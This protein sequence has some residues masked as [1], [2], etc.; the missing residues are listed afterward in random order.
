M[1]SF[2]GI[3]ALALVCLLVILSAVEGK[4][5]RSFEGYI[6]EK[7]VQTRDG[8]IEVS[9]EEYVT[10]KANNTKRKIM[11]GTKIPY[12][13]PPLAQLRFQAPANVT[14]WTDP[15]NCNRG[16][17]DSIPACHQSKKM[18]SMEDQPPEVQ[19]FWNEYSGGE[20]TKDSITATEYSEDCLYLNVWA[21][22]SKNGSV[23]P[24]GSMGVG[25]FVHG[26]EFQYD[27]AFNNLYEGTSVAFGMN[28]VVVTF[29]YRLG[30]FGFLHAP[31]EKT[32]ANQAR[33]NA[34]LRDMAK[35]LEWVHHN[36]EHWGGLKEG[37]VLYGAGSGAAAVQYLMAS[38]MVPKHHYSGAILSSGVA[39]SHMSF[40][41]PEMA[42]DSAVGLSKEL[43]NSMD[44]RIDLPTL[45]TANAADIRNHARE[46]LEM[47]SSMNGMGCF[48]PTK[49][50]FFPFTPEEALKMMSEE[51]RDHDPKRV[52]IGFN[53]DEG[54][55]DVAEHGWV[56]HH[57]SV[58][59]DLSLRVFQKGVK[60][61]AP[62][63]MTP[64][65]MDLVED[66]YY[67]NEVRNLVDF[68]TDYWYK[69]EILH[70]AQTLEKS[71][72]NERHVLKY[73]FDSFLDVAQRAYPYFEAGHGLEKLMV[74]GR[75][76]MNESHYSD[77]ER[78]LSMQMMKLWVT[79]GSD[80]EGS[81]AYMA[82]E[83]S[84]LS[85][86]K[87]YAVDAYDEMTQFQKI[88]DEKCHFVRCLP[89]L[90]HWYTDEVW[91]D[92]SCEKY[93]MEE[94]DSG[95][96]APMASLALTLIAALLPTLVRRA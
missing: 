45:E 36:I 37:V 19:T 83:G 82:K 16:K 73:R 88:Q 28:I 54:S 12:A 55:F 25:F 35:A 53:R 44:G 8:P 20:Y 29:N 48:I 42:T 27:S 68:V 87:K 74:W 58:D 67:G 75:P 13:K 76:Y 89:S 81:K 70:V 80:P 61:V 96:P 62:E 10:D 4:K 3:A 77:F 23:H 49:D 22:L 41:S 46:N 93:T 9:M 60:Y 17:L 57:A 56:H 64:R 34:G 39:G 24:P 65:V 21:P 1:S 66:K 6:G 30:P 50:D 47:S 2:S 31:A 72:T 15:K 85:I 26:G 78:G 52:M 79:F 92:K 5:S 32:G 86:D 18:K 59:D 71:K 63:A 11:V 84:V 40:Q 94:K 43:A 91:M 90:K 69:C 38:P 51:H 95:G 7:T 33:S 14:Q